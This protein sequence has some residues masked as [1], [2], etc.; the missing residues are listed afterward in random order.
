[1]LKLRVM[2]RGLLKLNFAGSYMR[3]ENRSGV[4][5]V[6]CDHVGNVFR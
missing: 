6:I 1:M 4:G 3:G 5:G 2:M